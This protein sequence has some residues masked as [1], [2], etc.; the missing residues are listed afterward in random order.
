MESN[1][2]THIYITIQEQRKDKRKIE[3]GWGL[4]IICWQSFPPSWMCVRTLPFCS[5]IDDDKKIFFIF[6]SFYFVST[7]FISVGPCIVFWKIIDFHDSRRMFKVLFILNTYTI[8]SFR[9]WLIVTWWL[10]DML[11][12]SNC[13]LILW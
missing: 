9:L 6:S 2:Y 4:G 7:L 8:T 10:V 11:S 3:R 12:S 5:S 13:A 1:A